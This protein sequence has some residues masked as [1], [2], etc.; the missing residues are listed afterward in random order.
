MVYKFV[1]LSDENESFIREFELL[2]SHTLFDFHNAL[3]N[4]LEFDKSQMASFFTA[5][6]NWEK[7]EEFTLLDMGTGS[8]PTMDS[9]ILEDVILRENQKLFYVFDL[10]NERGLLVEYTGETKETAG[11][12]LP[13]CTNAKGIPPKQ[14]V[15]GG[16]SSGNLYNNI[17]VSDDYEE[18]IGEID[19]LY[20]DEDDEGALSD[21]DNIDGLGEED[22]E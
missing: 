13:A 17:I 2:D 6:D 8:P 12:E 11:K 19:D 10:F 5:T 1:V 20:L 22:D 21:F 7:D 15:F 4:E 3:Q 9:A 18:D 14:V 16:K